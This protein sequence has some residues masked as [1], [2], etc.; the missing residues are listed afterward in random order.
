MC[1]KG[2]TL[3]GGTEEEG[4]LDVEGVPPAR[5]K[6]HCLI[7]AKRLQKENHRG[8]NKEDERTIR[9]TVGMATAFDIKRNIYSLTLNKRT[10]ACSEPLN[11]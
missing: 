7:T 3:P 1:K 11:I 2:L 9:E 8:F 5:V 10:F 4:G 6:V